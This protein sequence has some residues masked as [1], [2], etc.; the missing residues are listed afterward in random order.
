VGR[1]A[2]SGFELA[3][4]DRGQRVH[5]VPDGD[6]LSHYSGVAVLREDDGVVSLAKIPEVVQSLHEALQLVG[7]HTSSGRLDGP[8]RE[9]VALR[10]KQSRQRESPGTSPV[11]P[12]RSMQPDP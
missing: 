3:Q 9:Q 1:N 10:F 7:S 5:S 8:P 4:E 6:R 11:L 2:V 12:S